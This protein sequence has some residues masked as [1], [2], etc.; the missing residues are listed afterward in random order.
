MKTEIHSLLRLKTFKEVKKERAENIIGSRFVYAVK[1]TGKLKARLVAQGF[2]QKESIFKDSNSS[3]TANPV[4]LRI[5][6]KLVACR[7]LKMF[8][9]DFDSAYLNSVLPKPIYIRK[10]PGYDYALG[11]RKDTSKVLQLHK[12]LYG[13]QESGR[14]WYLSLKKE[15]LKLDLFC[16]IYDPCLFVNS[17]KSLFVLVYVDDCIVAGSESETANL[18]NKI[19]KVYSLK[20]T[21]LNDFLGYNIEQKKDYITLDLKKYIEKLLKEA[22]MDQCNLT[23]TP[24]AVK[25]PMFPEKTKPK[26]KKPFASLLGSLLWINGV[27]PDL[28]FTCGVLSRHTHHPTEDSWSILKR[29]LRYLNHTKNFALKITKELEPLGVSCFTDASFA[30]APGHRSFGGNVI[31]IGE[32]V[33]TH[34]SRIQRQVATSTASCELNEIYRGSN[35]VLFILGICA[36]LDLKVLRPTVYSDAK[37]ALAL[38]KGDNLKRSTKHLAVKIA[39]VRDLK[40]Q[41]IITYKYVPTAENL[42]DIQTKILPRPKFE[43]LSTKIY[44]SIKSPFLRRPVSGPRAKLPNDEKDTSHILHKDKDGCARKATVN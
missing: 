41:K 1:R 7:N 12:A 9:I 3:P 17:R 15:L 39:Y 2:M 37:S 4:T 30:N 18:L 25:T 27:R 24:M 16:S 11:K 28:N 21:D 20:K 5:L 13:L 33:V 8:S 6:L 43:E 32:T 14:L 31:F 22:K 40:D 42:A 35:E 36:E 44:G 19:K 34:F 29:A 38:I 26:I 10:P 23:K